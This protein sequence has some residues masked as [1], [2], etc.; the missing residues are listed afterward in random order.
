MADDNIGTHPVVGETQQQVAAQSEQPAERAQLV[1]AEP[2]QQITSQAGQN[3][4]GQQ[5]AVVQQP[6]TAQQQVAVQ[7]Q[8]QPARSGLTTFHLFPRL[9]AEI[10]HKIL[11][12]AIRKPNVHFVSCKRAH[13]NNAGKWSFSFYP[14]DVKKADDPSGYR[15]LSLLSE[16][17][18]EAALAVKLATATD[19][20]RAVKLPF[21]VLMNQVDPVEDL[22]CFT[23]RSS[24]IDYGYLHPHYQVATPHEFD[25]DRCANTCRT[26]QK[27]ALIV[28]PSSNPNPNIGY[29]RYSFR[30]MVPNHDHL[31]GGHRSMCPDE[32]AS[33]VDLFPS[34]REVY[35]ILKGFPVSL[36]LYVF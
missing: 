20:N 18:D 6:V 26:Y 27:I 36:S 25:A 31:F 29:G 35:F 16:V 1:T 32:V 8:Q 22:I 9:P 14:L 2:E 3:G 12:D 33:F 24:D 13:P 21:R 15:L 17:N 19:G 11:T 23:F 4:G 34:V 7:S 28:N 5:Q 10:R 30:C